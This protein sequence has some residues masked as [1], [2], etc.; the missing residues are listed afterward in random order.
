M[1]LKNKDM[2]NERVLNNYYNVGGFNA[3]ARIGYVMSMIRK[4]RPLT[5]DEWKTW[6]FTNVHDEEYLY[7]L[8]VEM[9]SSIPVSYDITIEDCKDYIYDVM[10]RRTFQGFDR[11]NQALM[12]LRAVIDPS[13]KE[14]P[15][16]WDTEYFIDFYLYGSDGKLIGI[17]LKPDTFYYGHYYNVVDIRG[18]MERFCREND[19]KA[20]VLQY[21]SNGDI[22]DIEFVNPEVVSDIK[23]LI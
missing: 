9:H 12:L 11:E 17:Q 20:F 15:K 6:Y 8:A 18:K 14:A 7:Q 23:A 21:I 1:R 3:P 10:F 13:V 5:V 4:L 22:R 19:A 2:P 16:E